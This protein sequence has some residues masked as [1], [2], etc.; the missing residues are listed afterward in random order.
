MLID[1]VLSCRANTSPPD[2]RIY[3]SA[4]RCVRA[5]LMAVGS[6]SVWCFFFFPRQAGLF[7]PANQSKQ[8]SLR[9]MQICRMHSRRSGL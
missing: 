8:S 7:K 6:V 9:F 5:T 3:G 1:Y 4:R 2:D